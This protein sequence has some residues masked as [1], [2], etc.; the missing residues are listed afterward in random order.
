MR[1]SSLPDNLA[2]E[3]ASAKYLIELVETKTRREL[4][5][6]ANYLCLDSSGDSIELRRSIEAFISQS[7]GRLHVWVAPK[8]LM[9][10]LERMR[11]L[12]PSETGARPKGAPNRAASSP[13]TAKKT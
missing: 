4:A 11:L 5:K 10:A 3:I 9:S 13:D 12:S 7:E 1:G 2:S 8:R 6:L